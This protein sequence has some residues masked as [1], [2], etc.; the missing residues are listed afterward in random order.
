MIKAGIVTLVGDNYGNKFQ[1]Y[2]V[3]QLL[4][5][6]GE[7]VTYQVEAQPRST[8][9]VQQRTLL[10]KLHPAY[11]REV[12]RCRLM[13]KFD[14]TNTER[15]LFG[16][17][18]YVLAHKK[19]LLDAKTVRHQKFSAY[20]QKYLHISD[21]IITH[22]NC[23]DT[24]WNQSH[25]VFVCGSDQIWNPTYSTT[26]DLAF[27]SFAPGRSVALAP[28]FGLSFIPE[29]AKEKYKTWLQ[30]IDILSVREDAG[31]RIIM[32][33]IGREAQVL[34]DPTMAIEPSC[35]KALAKA[36]ERKL[37]DRYILTYFLGRV[38]KEYKSKIRQISKETGLPVVNLFNIE[39]PERYVY[40][41]NEVLYAILNAS[42]VLTDSFH[43]TVFSILFRRDFWVFQRDEGML[44]M[45]SRLS[46]LLKMFQLE[47]RLLSDGC[48]V[49]SN[50]TCDQWEYVEQILERE[51]GV[52]RTY[53]AHG[54]AH[55]QTMNKTRLSKQIDRG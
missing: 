21:R 15:S 22:E 32:D 24:E 31:K 47:D 26:S 17:F 44:N 3:E 41:P 50:V 30:G 14:I 5:E 36:P 40:D 28:S 27:L 18:L 19:Q 37:P 29:D 48:A 55:I 52:T 9:A 10:Q 25:D 13:Y 12:L 43:G 38:S 39:E 1:N 33:L 2:A 4:S 6:Y 49:K 46:T 34:L 20:Q 8:T 23:K 16:N 53:I 42:V 7:V 11:V 35:W 51:Q 45:S 54:I